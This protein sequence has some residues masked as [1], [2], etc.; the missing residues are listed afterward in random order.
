MNKKNMYPKNYIKF[1]REERG[2]SL[3]DLA[4]KTGWHHQTISN[5][6][7]SKAD[8]TWSKILVLADIFEVHPSEITEGPVSAQTE[9][10][11]KALELLR[12][13]GEDDQD[14][15]IGLAELKSRKS[16]RKNTGE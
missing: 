2:W 9:R 7:L 11:K 13:L 6:E 14:E 1:L 15:L 4:D 10:E 12:N 8:L 16:S 5:L 3:R